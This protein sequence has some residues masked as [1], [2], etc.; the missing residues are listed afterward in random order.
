MSETTALQGA[1]TTYREDK[2]LAKHLQSLKLTPAWKAV[3]EEGFVTGL[4]NKLISELATCDLDT[5]QKHLSVL[6]GISALTQY[7][8]DVTTKGEF[9]AQGIRE[10]EDALTDLRG[11]DY[12]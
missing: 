4:A 6:T 7:L 1:L 5:K 8:N 12:E 2:A 9:A 10:T 11:I 3:I